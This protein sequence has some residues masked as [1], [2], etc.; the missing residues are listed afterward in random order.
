M[1]AISDTT[2]GVSTTS[3]RVRTISS[4]VGKPAVSVS[5]KRVTAVG[6]ASPEV[7]GA[8]QAPL[9]R[10]KRGLGSALQLKLAED[11]ADVRLDRLLADTELAGNLLIRLAFRE[12]SKHG[13]FP[14]REYLRAPGN[15]HLTHQ[16]RGGL[17]GQMDLA[18][19]G[20]LDGLAKLVGL[21]VLDKIADRA[22]ANG[23]GDRGIVQHAGQGD[24]LDVRH[25]P[26]DH[27]RC[28]HAPHAWHQRSEERR[29]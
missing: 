5:D 9:H 11:V 12:E 27:P 13:C 10:V 2:T 19:G 23:A 14:F 16:A 3:T 25:L 17:R 29:V 4:I 15:L 28:R 26:P 7:A 20:R 1:P 6:S 18:R 24:H 22:G 8:H 21:R